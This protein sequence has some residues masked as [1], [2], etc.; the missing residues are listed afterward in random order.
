MKNCSPWEGPTSDK[1]VKDCFMWDRPHA[2][3]GEKR[4]EEGATETM[5]DELTTTPIPLVLLGVGRR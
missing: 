4:E 2:G 3:A 1:F 5:C